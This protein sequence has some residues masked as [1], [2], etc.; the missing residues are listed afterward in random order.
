[1]NAATADSAGTHLKSLCNMKTTHPIST[2][3]YLLALVQICAMMAL[4]AGDP[5]AAVAQEIHIDA[6]R[7]YE[8]AGQCMDRK[9]Y[10]VAAVEWHRFIHF[11]P[12]DRRVPLAT[13]KLA[14]ARFQLEDFA[15]A[16]NGLKPLTTDA[17]TNPQLQQKAYWLWVKCLQRQGDTTAVRALLNRLAGTAEQPET[18][19]QARYRLGWSSLDEQQWDQARGEFQAIHP[20]FDHLWHIDALMADLDQVHTL[21]LKSPRLAGTLSILPGGGQLYCERPRDAL[22]AFAVNVAFFAATWEAFEQD[23]PVIGGLLGVAGVGFYSGNI[24]NAASSAHKYNLV[25]R[26]KHLRRL[27]KKHGLDFTIS[28]K[29]RAGGIALVWHHPF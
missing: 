6:D 22:V 20:P 23:M 11:F 15:A 21:P 5:K 10:A 28:A 7:Q 16:I 14:Q 1:M 4:I 24:Y 3:G 18:R 2:I 13:F 26:R 25:Q 19:N 12:A 9:E 27:K 8:Y 29:P 17:R